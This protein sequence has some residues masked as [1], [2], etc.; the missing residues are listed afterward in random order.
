[1]KFDLNLTTKWPISRIKIYLDAI[2]FNGQNMFLAMNFLFWPSKIGHLATL[3]LRP[4]VAS[5]SVASPSHAK[6]SFTVF[7]NLELRI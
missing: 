1:M 5:L 2:V 4:S 7:F 3:V 6:P